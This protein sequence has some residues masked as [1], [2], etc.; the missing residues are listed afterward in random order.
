[1]LYDQ[2]ILFEMR[3]RTVKLE[4]M[5]HVT[6][7]FAKLRDFISTLVP[8]SSGTSTSP[9]A[10]VVNEQNLWDDPHED[11]QGSDV[12]SPHDDVHADGAEMQEGNDTSGEGSD[13]RSTHDNDH[14]DEGEIHV[15]NDG[16]GGDEQTPE[17]DNRTEEGDMQDMNDPGE[18]IPILPSDDEEGPSTHGITEVDGMC[19]FSLH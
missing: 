11:G 19:F 3:L 1:M 4:I 14:A 7:E 5:Q 8:P 18:T 12:R 10:P 17:D 13:K 2:R 9:I 16:E 15:L 6:E